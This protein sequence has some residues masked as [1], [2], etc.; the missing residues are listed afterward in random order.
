MTVSDLEREFGKGYRAKMLKSLVADFAEDEET[1]LL[2]DEVCAEI[3]KS[4]IANEDLVE[5]LKFMPS[6]IAINIARNIENRNELE[7]IKLLNDMYLV[8]LNKALYEKSDQAI[9]KKLKW[10]KDETGERFLTER[11]LTKH[12]IDYIIQREAKYYGEKD[13]HKYLYTGAIYHGENDNLKKYFIVR[14]RLE[15]P[16]HKRNTKEMI[17]KIKKILLNDALKKLREINSSVEV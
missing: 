10:K 11:L 7:I 1:K 3:S 8:D 2:F 16:Q 6:K 9:E 5:L 12:E 4:Q 14:D 17:D 13:I 15:K